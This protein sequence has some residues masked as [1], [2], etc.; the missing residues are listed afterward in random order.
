MESIEK[1]INDKT[2][3]VK[4]ILKGL[5]FAYP[6]VNYIAL[7]PAITSSNESQWK[8]NW[9]MVGF[10]EKPSLAIIDNY[11]KWVMTENIT[12]SDEELGIFVLSFIS[13]GYFVDDKLIQQ[14]D[15]EFM[16]PEDLCFTLDDSGNIVNFK[17]EN[18]PKIEDNIIDDEFKDLA[19]LFEKNN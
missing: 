7:N 9:Y 4:R 2:F 12:D 14:S 19:D 6:N 10:E 5:F 11:L 13:E 1:P 8:K 16:N 18:H 15:S 17:A 3:D